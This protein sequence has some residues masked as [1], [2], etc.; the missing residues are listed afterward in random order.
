ME[1]KILIAGAC[2]L[3]NDKLVITA[4]P[5]RDEEIEEAVNRKKSFFLEKW[6]DKSLLVYTSG[7]T[8]KT[9][10][11]EIQVNSSLT[12]YKLFHFLTSLDSQHEIKAGDIIEIV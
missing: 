3:V 9:K 5:K 2:F 7:K 12:N 8:I 10:I 6:K 11:V 1:F 4:T